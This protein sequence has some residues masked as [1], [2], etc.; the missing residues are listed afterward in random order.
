[1]TADPHGVVPPAEGLGGLLL[2]IDDTLLG[3]R[4]AM[5]SAGGVAAQQLWPTTDARRALDAGRRYRADPDG[6]FRAYTRGECDFDTMRAWRVHDVASWLGAQPAA[7]DADRWAAL[8][9]PAFAEALRVFDDVLPTLE[10]CRSAGMPVALLTNSSTAYT[11]SKLE[12]CDLD[13]VVEDLTAGVLTKDTLGCGKPAPEVFHHG[14]ALLGLPPG[15]VA[16]IGDELDYDVLAALDAGLGA[17]WVLREGYERDRD[18]LRA[19]GERGLAPLGGLAE[20]AEALAGAAR[21][22]FWRDGRNG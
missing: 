13:G 3:T 6:H 11:T 19:A 8:F 12:L 1:M 18:D 17:A 10:R 7:G 2:D 9:D 20:A 14:C 5:W 15:R 16:Y 4:A 21:R 22:G